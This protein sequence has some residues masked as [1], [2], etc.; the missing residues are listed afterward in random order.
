MSFAVPDKLKYG[1]AKLFLYAI[2]LIAG[3]RLGF[4]SGGLCGIWLPVL[5]F[6]I[7]FFI[8][9]YGLTGI[10]LKQFILPAVFI[11]GIVNAACTD[12]ARRRILDENAGLFG[13]APL[14][15][16]ET[17]GDIDIRETKSG[18]YAVSFVSHLGAM[19]VKVKMN[20]APGGIF[21]AVGDVWLCRGMIGR[22]KRFEERPYARRV[23][24]VG[25]AERVR[26]KPASAFTASA[27]YS[28][29]SEVLSAGVTAGMEW[30]KDIVGIHKAVLLGRRN[31]MS[32]EKQDIF[33]SAGTIHIVAIS[34][35]HVGLIAVMLT[36]LLRR[37]DIHEPYLS[38][39]AIP[40][41]AAYIM[42]TGARPSAVR[43]AVMFSLWKAAPVFR[44]QSDGLTAW[45]LTAFGVYAVSPHMIFDA[46][47]TLSFVVMLGIV[48]WCKWSKRLNSVFEPVNR[49]AKFFEVNGRIVAARKLRRFKTFLDRAT[50]KLGIT[51]AAWIAGVPVTAMIFESVTPGG[52]IAN[53]FVIAVSDWMVRFGIAGLLTGF[54]CLPLG[55]VF[56]N[57]S[58]LCT[59]AMMRLSELV[60]KI[61]C[62]TFKVE[63]WDFYQCA[64]WYAAWILLFYLLGR[65]LPGNQ[66]T[67]GKWWR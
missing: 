64:L 3:E 46:G 17:E 59:L 10:G 55:A 2:I 53:L 6:S 33:R 29:L 57:L 12:S 36:G 23:V 24:W 20:V 4:S 47:C 26:V 56:N 28:S 41:I 35:L 7:W 42:L 18:V 66:K 8:T 14:L 50:G 67:N 40:V 1:P 62:C 27:F 15:E 22:Q 13:D 39:I 5:V 34:G 61:P 54:V 60:A 38:L 65:I 9:L 45:S 31:E 32:K 25:E 19:P 49:R 37:L 63:A 48:L 21:P 58:A 51:L 30:S 44:R 11:F 43:A 16:L 52:L